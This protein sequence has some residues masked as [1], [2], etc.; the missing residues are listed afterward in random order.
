MENYLIWDW[1]GTLLNDVAAAVGALNRMLKKRG[2]A[3]VDIDF[4]RGNFGFPVRPFYEKVGI[5]FAKWDWDGICVDFHEFVLEE[6]QAVREDARAALESA[7]KH[8]L[9]QCILSALRQDMLRE[10]VEKN[11]FTG[12][13]E[14]VYGVDNLDGASKM[15]RGRE[16][17]S[18]LGG[19]VRSAVMIGDTLHDAEV[20]GGLGARCVLVAGGHQS[21]ER[22]LAAGCPVAGNL[23]EAV[24][25]AAS[26]YGE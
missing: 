19:N 3:P 8:G 10:A 14:R 13:F 24:E 15:S 26:L 25:I 22:L 11:G 18:A 20:A 6:P 23:A 7:A 12:F 16:L 21:R 17:M 5:D 9:R 4:Y 1:N 2:L